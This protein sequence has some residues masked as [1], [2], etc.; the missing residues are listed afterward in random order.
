MNNIVTLDDA[1]N[2]WFYGPK[3]FSFISQSNMYISEQVL[4]ELKRKDKNYGAFRFVA[5]V[6]QKLFARENQSIEQ[7]LGDLGGIQEILWLI[8]LLAVS[9]VIDHLWIVALIKRIY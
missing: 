9:N 8:G 4:K 7:Y 3:N 5:D 1:I 2:K 6:Q